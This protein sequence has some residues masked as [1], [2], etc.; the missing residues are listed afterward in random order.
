MLYLGRLIGLLT[1]RALHGIAIVDIVMLRQRGQEGE[2]HLANPT[3]KGLLLHLDTLMFKKVSGLVEDLQALGT[4][5]RAVMAWQALVLMG[6]GEVSEVMATHPAFVGWLSS[7]D[8]CMLVV[9]QSGVRL[10]QDAVDSTAQ[11]VVSSAG[12]DGV[13]WEGGCPSVVLLRWRRL[14]WLLLLLLPAF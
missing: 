14:L 7:L 2:A 11:G 4:L 5:E 3:H 8:G 9:L 6:V 12:R 13:L 10:E 1:D